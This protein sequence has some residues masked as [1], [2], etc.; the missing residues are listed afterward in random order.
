M[1]DDNFV[2]YDF[3]N[4]S[5]GAKL[6]AS[7]SDGSL[8]NLYTDNLVNS[9]NG[10][11][12]DLA[13]IQLREWLTL[14]PFAPPIDGILASNMKLHYNDKYVWGNGKIFVDEFNY[15]RKRVGDIGFDAR[16]AY[17]GSSQ[18]CLHTL[19]WILTAGL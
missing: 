2:Q 19:E 14:S 18:K 5:I 4:G 7:T 6:L 10:I 1:N 16:L 3:R 8:I 9:D 12:V 13:G 15:G 17:V 11:N